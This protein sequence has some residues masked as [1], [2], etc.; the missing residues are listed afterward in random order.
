ML[1]FQLYNSLHW[2][3]IPASIFASYIILGMIYIG[4]EIEDPFGHDVNDLPLD[5]F[6][7]QI[8]N[9]VD[10]IAA[11]PKP[12]VQQFVRSMENKIMFPISDSGYPVWARRNELVIRSELKNKVQL[13]MEARKSMQVDTPRPLGDDKV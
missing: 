8:A 13:G 10:I 6:C 7:T 9:E 4:R 12:N 3:T 11:M 5:A 1:P 2:V